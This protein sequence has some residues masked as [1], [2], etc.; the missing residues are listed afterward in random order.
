VDRLRQIESIFR[1]ALQRDPAQRDA[2]LREACN[3]NTELQREVASRL[4][5]LCSAQFSQRFERKR[6]QLPRSTQ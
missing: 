2:Y 3:K 6:G 4:A 5:N 1:E